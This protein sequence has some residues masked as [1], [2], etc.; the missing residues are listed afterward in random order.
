[1]ALSNEFFIGT[2]GGKASPTNLAQPRAKTA[3]GVYMAQL[4]DF[5]FSLETAAFEE[6]N[7]ASEYR[8]ATQ[9]RIGRRPANQF[10]GPGEESIELV[11][12]IYPHFRG[13]LGQL[14]L[15]RAMAGD[16]MPLPLIYGFENV[17]QYAGLWC[18]KSIK[19]NR[20][21]FIRI[22]AAR[23]IEF[24]VSLVAYGEDEDIDAQIA[25]RLNRQPASG[26]AQQ[27]PPL[28]GEELSALLANSLAVDGLVDVFEADWGE[29]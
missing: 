14:G 9:H 25:A 6:L 10:L 17:G 23:K 21:E 11:G 20:S 26:D 1:M 3:G 16:G 4:G 24:T 27:P 2:E 8:W 29:A 7:R 5:Q 22:G 19:D 13:G 12:T 18:I 15:M 28:S